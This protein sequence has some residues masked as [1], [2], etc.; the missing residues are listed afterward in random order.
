MAIRRRQLLTKGQP[1]QWKID[2][3]E[4]GGV[5]AITAAEGGGS[6]ILEFYR[7]SAE[8]KAIAEYD[9]DDDAA[10]GF[11]QRWVLPGYDAVVFFRDNLAGRVKEALYD[12]RR[13]KT[14]FVLTP[15][16]QVILTLN[17]T[18]LDQLIRAMNEVLLLAKPAAPAAA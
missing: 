14:Q 3:H 2:L 7:G 1:H 4:A 10:P 8:D 5:V 6:A 13:M 15:G 18:D 9:I 17:R 11:I 16:V 12:K